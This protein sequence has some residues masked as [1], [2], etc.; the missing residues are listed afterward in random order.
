MT[1]Y[2]MDYKLGVGEILLCSKDTKGKFESLKPFMGKVMITIGGGYDKI[3]IVEE[4]DRIWNE[5]K[6][7]QSRYNLKKLFDVRFNN[8]NTQKFEDKKSTNDINRSP[9]IEEIGV[10]RDFNT[11]NLDENED[12]TK[13]QTYDYNEANNVTDRSNN[14]YQSNFFKKSGNGFQKQNNGENNKDKNQTLTKLKNN[15]NNNLEIIGE[16]AIE[17]YM[18]MGGEN[19]QPLHNDEYDFNN[20]NSNNANNPNNNMNQNMDFFSEK[21]Q[22]Y[23][24]LNSFKNFHKNLSNTQKKLNNGNILENNS[25][26]SNKQARATDLSMQ[27]SIGN[28]QNG[29]GTKMSF[30]DKESQ[31][32]QIYKGKYHLIK[33]TQDGKVYGCGESY[34]GV[35]GLGGSQSAKKPV[36]IPNLSNKKI[37]QIACGMFHSLA[38]SREGDLYSWGMGFEGQ[39]GLTAQYKCVSSPR[40]V[41]YFFNRPVKF[42]TCGHN[43][44]LCITYD[45]KL[46]GWGENKLGQLGLGKI[47]IVEKPTL[48]ELLDVPG[49]QEGCTK[50]DTLINGT[51]V[52]PYSGKNFNAC[53]VS[54]GFAHSAVVSHEGYLLTF[55][56]NIY[57]QLGLGHTHSVFEPKLIEKDEN[58]E[59]M[60]KIVKVNCNSSGTF[61][62]TDEG[63]LYTCGSGEIGHGDIG[64]IKL[65]R[66]INDNRVYSHIFCN[67]HSVV[68][69]CPLRIISVSP[70]SGPASGNTILSIIGSALKDFPKLSV[71]FIFGGVARVNIR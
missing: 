8:S 51:L 54:A 65:P 14:S 40:Y 9:D 11:E 47:Q 64:V 49:G 45:N 6:S 50:P 2:K 7:I 52:R 43:Y 12:M 62:I 34:F 3:Y 1:E 30:Q 36:I 10:G 44:S 70:N 31:I 27:K 35:C 42:I 56:L 29:M 4:K 38:L 61:M 58:G 57:G 28:D 55:G 25:L 5:V 33:L 32:V 26:Y 24:T 23:E 18:G 15:S 13:R 37:I 20:L 67:D 16:K 19:M 53:F 41:K 39:L 71:R 59:F 22:D 60:K 17:E 63:K 66:L 69:F 46:W 48:I 68:A 21:D